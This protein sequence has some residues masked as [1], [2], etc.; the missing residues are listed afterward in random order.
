[1]GAL[2]SSEDYWMTDRGLLILETTNNN[3]NTSLYDQITTHTLLTWV[4]TLHAAWTTDSSPDWA[5]EF[6]IQNSGTYNNQYVV[7]DAKVFEPGRLPDRDFIW[8]TETLPGIAVKRD[9]TDIFNR[10][11]YWASF[12]APW[13]NETF[14]AADYPQKIKD[15][16]DCGNF[17]SYY[18][19]SRYLIFERDAP[20]VASF[21]EFKELLRRNDYEND[22]LSNGDPGQQVMARYDLRPSDCKCG[23]RASSGGLDTKAT[24]VMTALAFLKFDAIGSPEYERH[25]PWSF[26]NPGF[27]HLNHDG[28]PELWNFSWTQF[29]AQ[30]YD[31]CGGADEKKKCVAIDYCGWCIYDQSCKLGYGDGPALGQVC[32]AGWSIRVPEKKWAIP[33]IAAVSGTSG[34]IILVLFIYHFKVRHDRTYKGLRPG[35]A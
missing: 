31:R 2:P 26:A 10:Q 16:G 23:K 14:Y 20:N 34:V 29:V 35:G 15:S 21:E 22:T 18:N 9:V 33:V 7:V 4:R 25:P 5:S 32:E 6:L 8:I 12:N 24:T 3:F 17:Y 13:F 19:S 11:G 30:G 1:M 27:E 28:L